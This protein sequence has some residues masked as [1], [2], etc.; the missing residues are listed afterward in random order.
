VDL[1]YLELYYLTEGN[2]QAVVSMKDIYGF[3]DEEL[4]Q[5]I[6]ITTRVRNADNSFRLRQQASSSRSAKVSK[7]IKKH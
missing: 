3:T 2:V 5:A 1:F 7:G 4:F 6:E